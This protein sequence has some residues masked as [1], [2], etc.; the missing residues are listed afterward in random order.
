[1]CLAAA[2]LERRVR[3]IHEWEDVCVSAGGWMGAY[4]CVCVFFMC[5]GAA[6]RERHVM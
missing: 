3:R 2:L 5:A 1:M 4:I 6:L